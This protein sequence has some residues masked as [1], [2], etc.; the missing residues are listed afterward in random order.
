MNENTKI[1]LAK[2]YEN[3]KIFGGRWPSGCKTAARCRRRWVAEQEFGAG[4]KRR[5][6]AGD[7]GWPSRCS[8]QVQKGGAVQ[9]D[10][11]GGCFFVAAL[12]FSEGLHQGG[13]GAAGEDHQQAAQEAG[14]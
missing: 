2:M 3:T 14:A 4:A 10:G 6:G 8:G 12:S 13:E 7:G 5:S 9:A 11:A 1:Y